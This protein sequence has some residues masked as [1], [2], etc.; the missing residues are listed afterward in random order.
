MKPLIISAPFG[1]WFNYDFATSTI[2]TYT[3]Y[4]RGGILKRIWRMIRTLRY[5]RK[6]KGWFN[7]LGLPNPGINIINGVVDSERILSIMGFNQQEWLYLMT[8][9]GF[10][11]IELNLSCPNVDHKVLISDLKPAILCGQDRLKRLIAKLS[12]VGWF[13]QINE[14]Y[15][16][17]ITIFHC[18]NTYP[19]TRGGLSGKALIPFVL[20]AMDRIRAKFGNRVVL[21]AGGGVTCKEDVDRYRDAGANHVAIASMLLNP[22]NWYKVEGLFV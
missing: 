5:N 2:G 15:D 3:R 11:N 20:R 9:N 16:L 14:L 22:L 12:P 13:N 17:G 10:K 7:A 4:Y 1:N 19:T 21:I 6:L 18:F 8:N